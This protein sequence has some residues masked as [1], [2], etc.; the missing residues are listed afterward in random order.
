MAGSP[1]R[2]A[3]AALAFPTG[4]DRQAPGN[5]RRP[6]D[7]LSQSRR[8]DPHHPRGGRAEAG[9]DGALGSHREPGRGDPQHAAALA[10]QARGIRDPQGIRRAD[11]RKGRHRSVARLRRQA[12]ADRRLG[13]RRGEEEVCQGDRT[14]AAAHAIRR[15]AGSR[16]TGDPARD[17]REGA[18]DGRH[19]RERLDPCAEG[20]S[21]RHVRPAVQGRRRTEEWRSRHRRRTGS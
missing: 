11:R 18:G 14:R 6:A 2:S 8:G 17:D 7:R 21:L 10:A 9:D 20:P 15:S 5:P 13:N 16:R 19:L 1:A 12:M 4:C 3:R